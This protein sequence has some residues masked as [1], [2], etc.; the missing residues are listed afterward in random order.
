MKTGTK[1]LSKKH[2]KMVIISS[3]GSLNLGNPITFNTIFFMMFFYCFTGW[4][5]KKNKS[6]SLTTWTKSTF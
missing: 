6:I 2:S 4:S 5:F 1:Q 3:S